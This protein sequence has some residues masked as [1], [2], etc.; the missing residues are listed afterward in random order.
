[1]E[2]WI[3]TFEGM[4]LDRRGRPYA[5]DFA[6]AREMDPE[7]YKEFAALPREERDAIIDRTLGKEPGFWEQFTR[8]RAASSEAPP[9][10]AA[11]AVAAPA[12]AREVSEADR[13]LIAERLEALKQARAIASQP[14]VEPE[15][16]TALERAA[17]DWRESPELRAEFGDDFARYVAWLKADERGI[18][19]KIG[20]R[21]VSFTAT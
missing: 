2:P 10:V 12:P 13:V 6:K 4:R 20:G 5:H 3:K 8:S 11:P 17:D 19:Q 15:R 7:E 14:V 18:T 16:R 1:M 21:V 9:V